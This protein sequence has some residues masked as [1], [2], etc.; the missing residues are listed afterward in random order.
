MNGDEDANFQHEKSRIVCVQK[1]AGPDAVGIGKPC[2]MVCVDL[3]GTLQAQRF[4]RHT[5]RSLVARALSEP[6]RVCVD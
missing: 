4:I 5:H 2:R 6:G 1:D 3:S